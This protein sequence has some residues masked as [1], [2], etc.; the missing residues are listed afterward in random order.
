MY[1]SVNQINLFNHSTPVF[2]LLSTHK[3]CSSLRQTLRRSI[4]GNVGEE[5]PPPP[6][7]EKAWRC[8]NFHNF[9][10]ANAERLTMLRRHHAKPCMLL[11]W[12]H[13]QRTHNTSLTSLQ[14]SVGLGLGYKDALSF[15]ATWQCCWSQSMIML[16]MSTWWTWWWGSIHPSSLDG[17]INLSECFLL[18]LGLQGSVGFNCHRPKAGDTLD[19]MLWWLLVQQKY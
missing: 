11:W 1:M 9:N 3:S 4:P 7:E 17:S 14:Q 19:K 12:S 16:I 6:G 13:C 15:F 5:V 2:V 18:H 10:V 8:V